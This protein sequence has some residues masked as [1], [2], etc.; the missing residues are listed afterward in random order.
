MS[1]Y[2]VLQRKKY[3]PPLKWRILRTKFSSQK[4]ANAPLTDANEKTVQRIGV[5]APTLVTEVTLTVNGTGDAAVNNAEVVVRGEGGV[6]A[7][8]ANHEDG[9]Y[10]F[11]LPRASEATVLVSAEGY[12]TNSSAISLTQTATATLATTVTLTAAAKAAK[13]N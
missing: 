3:K 9:T 1:I 12:Q 13:K 6:Y 4:A 2:A 8:V 10:T 11:T 5:T 7:T